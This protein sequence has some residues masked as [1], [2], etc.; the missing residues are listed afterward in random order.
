MKEIFAALYLILLR[1]AEGLPYDSLEDF[2]FSEYSDD[3]TNEVIENENVQRAPAFISESMQFIVNEGE[4][5]TLPCLVTRLQG[6]V[7]LWKKNERIITVGDQLLGNTNSRYHLD[8]KFNGNNLVIPHAES[9]DEGEYICQVSAFQPTMIRHSVRIRVRPK[10][11]TSP[12]YSLT[13]K[14]GKEARLY[15]KV[16]KGDDGIK[17]KWKHGGKELLSQS[18]GILI[19][20]FVTRHMSGVYDCVAEDSSALELIRRN[21]H[22]NVEF[23]PEI[24]QGQTHINSNEDNEVNVT[25]IVTGNPE[26]KVVWL[27]S[28]ELIREDSDGER[29]H[30]NGELYSLVLGDLS[31][32][33]HREYSCEASNKLGVASETFHVSGISK[34]QNVVDNSKV[35]DSYELLNSNE[36][37]SF[38]NDDL[39]GLRVFAYTKQLVT[40]LRNSKINSSD[41]TLD[42]EISSQQPI[43]SSLHKTNIGF[44]ESD[45]L[46]IL[47][48]T[49]EKIYKNSADNQSSEMSI[50]V[51]QEKHEKAQLKELED[52]QLISKYTEY[53]EIEK[54]ENKDSLEEIMDKEDSLERYD[55]EN[56]E[57]KNP[58]D[59]NENNIPKLKI[60]VQEE[61]E[62]EVH[63]D[64]KSTAL[65]SN[66]L[67]TEEE[68][69]AESEDLSSFLNTKE[70]HQ[71]S[72]QERNNQSV[73]NIV[74]PLFND[75]KI[76]E[77]QTDEMDV[78]DYSQV[79]NNDTHDSN[80]N[81][82]KMVNS[83]SKH[84][85]IGILENIHFSH[86]VTS[87]MQVDMKEVIHESIHR[88][89]GS[90]SFDQF[91][92]SL[93][94]NDIKI[95]GEEQNNL[96]IKEDTQNYDTV[97]FFDY[98][99]NEYPHEYK[100]EK[101]MN[102]ELTTGTK[103]NE[104]MTTKYKKGNS[105]QPSEELFTNEH[106]QNTSLTEVVGK[107]S[108]V[109]EKRSWSNINLVFD[110]EKSRENNTYD[111]FGTTTVLAEDFRNSNTMEFITENILEVND[112]VMNTVEI[113]R[114][115]TYDTP[116]N[117]ENSNKSVTKQLSKKKID[118]IK[119]GG[120]KNVE[121][122]QTVNLHSEKKKEQTS[123]L[124]D[125]RPAA[126]LKTASLASLLNIPQGFVLATLIFL[127]RAN[128]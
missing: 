80:F 83:A 3:L 82:E 12:V 11:R 72:D 44:E 4:T 67:F 122:Y 69:K 113:S 26:P 45:F 60:L 120:A 127:L 123:L 126:V 97:S 52:N 17:L 124:G 104:I 55:Y 35:V 103:S 59:K 114:E 40:H 41:F 64:Q 8:A 101:E 105:T 84:N 24:Q 1:A 115:N 23:A 110:S 22:L 100:R 49:N 62:T 30:R 5:I 65:T 33:F 47:Q 57:T 7:L 121:K 102:D 54:D 51:D 42:H 38:F 118:E 96:R 68:F 106:V 98:D 56:I 93:S 85:Q 95:P 99:F 25:C 79:E 77:T 73:S 78:N 94:L 19:L 28:G 6:F 107:Q 2:Y 89:N 111:S 34:D 86:N 21:V 10:L 125:S 88:Y 39:L 91:E 27:R 119:L 50:Q 74:Q 81:L 13:V 46:E 16:V 112:D 61:K 76:L 36:S 18:E 92:K 15:C 9:N 48:E 63:E 90:A 71:Y 109:G 116:T 75:G 70:K 32:K 87:S 43:E 37:D 128:T 117:F 14:E 66:S 53:S 58:I 20:D 108:A 29:I 31:E